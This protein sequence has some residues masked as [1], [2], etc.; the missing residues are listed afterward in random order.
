MRKVFLTI[1]AFIY[2]STSMGATV[3]LHYCMGSLKSW[4]F[5]DEA[6]KN[7]NYCGMPKKS[8]PSELATKGCCKDEQK[9]VQ[10][11]K[12]QKASEFAFQSLKFFPL[13]CIAYT[14]LHAVYYHSPIIEY[15][16]ANSPPLSN[17][18]SL[19]VVNCVYRI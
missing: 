8:N 11:E 2:L 9:H 17:D 10:I 12:D 6:A 5:A 4:G 3:H 7:C 13:I 15:P 14:Q 1:L 16:A 19:F 18:L